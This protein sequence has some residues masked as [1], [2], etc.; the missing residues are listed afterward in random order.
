MRHTTL[1]LALAALAATSCS[2]HLDS[3]YGLR[4][5]RR[6]PVDRSRSEVH[7]GIRQSPENPSMALEH[8]LPTTGDYLIQPNKTENQRLSTGFETEHS[9]D[10]EEPVN[11]DQPTL[12]PTSTEETFDEAGTNKELIQQETKR[13]PYLLAEFLVGLGFIAVVALSLILFFIGL[14]WAL[15]YDLY[16]LEEIFILWG[17]LLMAVSVA[18]V[19]LARK[20]SLNILRGIKK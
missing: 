15:L 16:W 13:M 7:D 14:A 5:D 18:L 8:E 20:V 6:V 17:L 3:Q 9:S 4:W 10:L 11:Y 1:L 19:W 2:L 12:Q